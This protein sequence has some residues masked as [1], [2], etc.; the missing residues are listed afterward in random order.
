MT[1]IP[2]VYA[3]S[4]SR[5]IWTW[6]STFPPLPLRLASKLQ[7]VIKTL[8]LVQPLNCEERLLLTEH[9]KKLLQNL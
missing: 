6:F 5:T 4:E 3:L 8:V 2:P 9:G 1:T 7:N